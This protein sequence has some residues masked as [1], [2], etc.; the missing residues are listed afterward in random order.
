MAIEARENVLIYNCERNMCPGMFQA[1][2]TPLHAGIFTLHAGIYDS[3]WYL[4]LIL[5]YI[6]DL[7]FMLVFT[8][9]AGI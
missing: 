2:D 6:Y 1:L 3:C 9:H 8:L 5:V 4:H 7:H